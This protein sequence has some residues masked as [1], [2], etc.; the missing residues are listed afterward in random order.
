MTK[1]Q[2]ALVEA[3]LLPRFEPADNE[4]QRVNDVWDLR[5]VV[6]R[7][8]RELCCIGQVELQELQA[9]L[10]VRAKKGKDE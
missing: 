8:G 5:L 10:V 3:K 1:L 4:A 6:E 9:A 2:R 7:L